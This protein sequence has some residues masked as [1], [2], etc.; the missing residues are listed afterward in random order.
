MTL[1]RDNFGYPGY[2]NNQGHPSYQ[3]FMNTVQAIR[4]DAPCW[5]DTY[6]IKRED[7]RLLAA[8]YV[9]GLGISPLGALIMVYR[10]V[11]KKAQTTDIYVRENG[12]KSRLRCI[13]C[14]R[15]C[16]RMSCA[17]RMHVAEEEER[18]LRYASMLQDYNPKLAFL[19]ACMC[20][21]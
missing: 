5:E 6:P 19:R 18:V 2:L 17:P 14:G 8:Y 10:L 4:K 1:T 3:D 11:Y 7:H 15:V 20:S 12:N 21:T 9:N 13:V 16:M